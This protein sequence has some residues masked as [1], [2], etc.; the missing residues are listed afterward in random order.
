VNLLL[1]GGKKTS[2]SSNFKSVCLVRI[3]YMVLS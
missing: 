3:R 1:K 2:I